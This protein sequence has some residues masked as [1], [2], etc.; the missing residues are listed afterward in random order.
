[1]VLL[2]RPLPPHRPASWHRGFTLVELLVAITVVGILMVAV[3]G[4]LSEATLMTTQSR[5]QTDIDSQSRMI[6][7]RMGQDFAGMFKRTDVDYLFA[8][9]TG[10]DTLFFYSDAPALADT[11]SSY[12]NPTALI[13]YR[14]NASFQL[15]RLGSGLVW[16]GTPPDGAAFLTYPSTPTAIPPPPDPN[17]TF[18]NPGWSNLIGTAP[19]FSNGT[20]ADYYHVL[21]DAVFRL[22]YCFLLKPLKQPNG[23]VLPACYSNLAYR[24]AAQGATPDPTTLY[25]AGST[26][27]TLYGLGVTNVEAIVVTLALVDVKSRQM[28]T[29]ANLQTLAAALPDP[30]DS[31]L[32]A[33]PPQ[34]M[35]QTWN[36]SLTSIMNS[37]LPRA[38]VG[39]VHVYQRT[40]YLGTLP[41]N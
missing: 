17:S 13:G 8:K 9:S 36:A 29:A 21:G 12:Q 23:T 6:F 2:K 26:A 19:A 25:A 31:N 18:L 32:S 22:E 3:I 4:I 10:N 24:T 5:K 16:G 41:T 7:D 37:G 38:A 15:E 20:A 40:F 39:N 35:A 28:L 33:A 14:V 34:L 1:M 27:T 11:A 30:Q